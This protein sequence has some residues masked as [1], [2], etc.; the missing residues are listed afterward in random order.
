MIL[1]LNT[2]CPG[3]DRGG[4]Q[5]QA[6]RGGR[7]RDG[8][9]ALGTPPMTARTRTRG[10]GGGGGGG[11]VARLRLAIRSRLS[12]SWACVQAPH[13]FKNRPPYGTAKLTP[14]AAYVCGCRLHPVWLPFAARV[15]L[16]AACR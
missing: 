4:A 11:A 6:R 14:S 15:W 13:F 9:D 3:R 8:G 7:A 12:G 16:F 5:S 1:T 2:G 10:G